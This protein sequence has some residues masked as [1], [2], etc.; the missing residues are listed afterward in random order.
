[1]NLD[2]YKYKIELHA[3]TKP[4]SGCSSVTP[5]RMAQIYKELGYDAVV[6]TNHMQ[7]RFHMRNFSSKEEMLETY[8]EGYRRA[9]AEGDK[10]GINVILGVEVFLEKSPADYLI[11]GIDEDFLI[12]ASEN[13]GLPLPEFYALMKNDKNVILQAHPFRNNTP[14]M[15]VDSLDGIETFNLHPEH[16]SRVGIA[17]RYA[18]E[19]NMKITIC[20]SDFHDEP[21]Y[22]LAALRTKTLPKDSFEL[23]AVLKTCDFL[24]D[25]SGNIVI[26]RGFKEEN[27]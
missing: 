13:L 12:R 5:E 7:P 24:F 1:M 3:H 17:A 27:N 14:I 18:A 22:G 6:I 10:L 25:F 21:S 26:P 15:P 4:C 9:K 2:D 8:I 11:Y 23:A 20:G 16:N 19:N